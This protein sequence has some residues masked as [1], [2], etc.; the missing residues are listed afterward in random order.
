MYHH[1]RCPKC[2]LRYRIQS[3]QEGK[4]GKC[5]QCNT[6]LRV[7]KIDQN[8]KPQKT[9]VFEI[10]A[11]EDF[12]IHFRCPSCFLKY[13]VRAEQAGKPGRCKQCNASLRVP[14]NNQNP[15]SGILTTLT[16]DVV[17]KKPVSLMKRVFES[18]IASAIVRLP[19]WLR[20]TA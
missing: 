18:D 11:V 12:P 6:L 16:V 15:E 13:T 3:R 14:P 10:T 9:G 7:P 8:G 20:H 4:S 17:V 2:F 19:K 5:R 1:Y